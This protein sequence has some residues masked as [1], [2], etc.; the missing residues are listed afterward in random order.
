[1]ADCGQDCYGI[2]HFLRHSSAHLCFFYFSSPTIFLSPRHFLILL[3]LIGS[4]FLWA[5]LG[6]T[7]TITNLQLLTS[8]LFQSDHVYLLR[9]CRRLQVH[10]FTLKTHSRSVGLFRARDRTVAGISIWPHTTLTRNRQPCPHRDSNPQSQEA[11]GH[12]TKPKTVRP[13]GSFAITSGVVKSGSMTW[14]R[15][16]FTSRKRPSLQN[17]HLLSLYGNRRIDGESGQR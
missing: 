12:N 13:P 5:S 3:L 9:R 16:G 11:N 2:D 6:L 17:M 15:T 4:Q 14:K 7:K 10:L 8:I 1:M